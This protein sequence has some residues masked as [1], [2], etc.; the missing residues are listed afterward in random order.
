M[1]TTEGKKTVDAVKLMRNARDKISSETEG[2]T[3]QELK[4]YIEEQMEKS[5]SKPVG[6]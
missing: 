3:L 4:K 2:M 5:K 1:K 6:K